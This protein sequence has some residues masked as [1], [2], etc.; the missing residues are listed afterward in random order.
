MN[1]ST[2]EPVLNAATLVFALAAIVFACGVVWRVEKK[3]DLSFKLFLA[4]IAVF[5]AGEL[6]GIFYAGRFGN[7]ALLPV[8]AKALFTLLF[9]WGMLTMRNMLRNIDGEK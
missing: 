4:A 1:I 9:L 8:A 3:L 5:F 7:W 6:A 2:I